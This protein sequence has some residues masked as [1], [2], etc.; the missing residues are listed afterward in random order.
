MDTDAGSGARRGFQKS[1]RASQKMLRAA[2]TGDIRT[3]EDELLVEYHVD[4]VD[5]GGNGYS[6]LHTASEAGKDACVG[7]LIEKGCDVNITSTKH[8][9]TPL[10]IAGSAA[11]ARLLLE[12]GASTVAKDKRRQTPLQRF[13]SIKINGDNETRVLVQ[14]ILDVL[15]SWSTDDGPQKVGRNRRRTLIRSNS[16]AGLKLPAIADNQ[17]KLCLPASLLTEPPGSPIKPLDKPLP[18]LFAPTVQHLQAAARGVEQ[19]SEVLERTLSAVRRDRRETATR[20]ALEAEKQRQRDERLSGMPSSPKEEHEAW[21]IDIPESEIVF[22]DYDDLIGAGGQGQVFK[23]TWHRTHVAVKRVAIDAEGDGD[24]GSEV[25]TRGV[26]GATERGVA[27]VDKKNINDLRKESRIL[28][29]L[30]HPN[31]LQFLGCHF[32]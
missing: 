22:D 17:T 18:R 29:S 25:L 6:S 19:G 26:S 7:W 30:K 13:R 21:E 24:K 28:S 20:R 12:A 23:A 2:A 32:Q 8:G 5:T 16:G 15:V 1:T 10:H 3:L 27:A 9:H 11:V 14:Q 4:A 31:I